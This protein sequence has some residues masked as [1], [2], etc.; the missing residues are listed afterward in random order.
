MLDAGLGETKLNTFLSGQNIPPVDH[1]SLKRWE[2]CVGYAIEGLADE[3]CKEAI[4]QEKE[5]TISTMD[6][7]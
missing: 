6:L 2:R 1:K 5:L 3:S 4:L 7:K